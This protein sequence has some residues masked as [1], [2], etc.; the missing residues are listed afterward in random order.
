[1]TELIKKHNLDLGRLE[2]VLVD[3]MKKMGNGEI[4]ALPTGTATN[5]I[6]YN[7]DI[8]DKFGVDYPTDGMTWDEFYEL[9][10]NWIE[11][12]MVFPIPD[13]RLFKITSR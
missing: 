7:K 12:A 5:V 1:M 8:F 13:S 10:K 6:I 11:K 3:S 2:P 4:W 9:A